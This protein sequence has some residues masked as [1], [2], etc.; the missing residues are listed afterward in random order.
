MTTTCPVWPSQTQVT[1]NGSG[2]GT[3][4]LGPTG[5]GV[6]WTLGNISVKTVQAVST[7]VCECNTY[8]GDDASQTNFVQGTFSGDT[9]DS[10]D[11][12]SGVQVRLGKYVWAVWS[13][14]VP[15]DIATLTITGTM[16]IP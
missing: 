6:V 13:G 14:G 15:G 2:A 5:H 4:R 11:A 7:G 12:A 16:E 10:T 9:G 3:A 8:V 1:L